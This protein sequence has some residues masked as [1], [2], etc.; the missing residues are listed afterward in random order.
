MLE[1][2]EIKLSKN[3]IAT[4]EKFMISVAIEEKVD[5]PFDYPFDFQPSYKKREGSLDYPYDYPFD[6]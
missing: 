2:T 3:V 1:I 6:L 4:G 5:Y